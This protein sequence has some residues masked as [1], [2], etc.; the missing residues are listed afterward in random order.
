MLG[1]FKLSKLKKMQKQSIF[2]VL[3][4][5]MCLLV[6][7]FAVY[8]IIFIGS[9]IDRALDVQQIVVPKSQFDIQGFE[10]LKLVR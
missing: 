10:N 5:V 1:K 6:G 3:V 9:S 4:I 2:L 8:S 7:G